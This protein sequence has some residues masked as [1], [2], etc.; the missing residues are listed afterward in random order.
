MAKSVGAMTCMRLPSGCGKDFSSLRASM[1]GVGAAAVFAVAMSACIIAQLP[2]GRT[3]LQL[4]LVRV[5][6]RLR[7]HEHCMTS[8]AELPNKTMPSPEFRECLL[9]LAVSLQTPL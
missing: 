6:G 7:R 2:P 1:I 3:L 8:S 9:A 4:G 5:P